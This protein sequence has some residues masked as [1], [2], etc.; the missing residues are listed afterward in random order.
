MTSPWQAC[1]YYCTWHFIQG[2][3]WNDK[4][5]GIGDSKEYPSKSSLDMD[6]LYSSANASAPFWW[7]TASLS[8]FL[9]LL[10]CHQE[11]KKIQL[12]QEE[13]EE[14]EKRWLFVSLPFWWLVQPG[15][16][17]MQSLQ[18]RQLKVVIIVAIQSYITSPK[19]YPSVSHQQ[20]WMEYGTLEI[21]PTHKQVLLHHWGVTVSDFQLTQSQY[22]C[23]LPNRDT[24]LQQ[25]P[26][27][28]HHDGHSA[29]WVYWEPWTQ[30]IH[31]KIQLNGNND[32]YIR[33]L[34]GD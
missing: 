25:R 19:T 20:F 16:I 8:N 10:I 30:M 1:H 13:Q 15:V 28:L 2:P 17:S 9:A 3:I 14:K 27:P 5:T 7:D 12:N 26:L 32:S 29:S 4:K 31:L 21:V 22:T 18:L 34:L 33:K 24:T 11:V 6:I 23:N